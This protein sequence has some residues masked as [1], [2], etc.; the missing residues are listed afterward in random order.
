MKRL[1]MIAG[2]LVSFPSVVRA[3]YFDFD[4]SGLMGG[5]YGIAQTREN[6]NV[7]NDPYR[8]VYRADVTTKANYH[9]SDSHYIGVH[10]NS[11]LVLREPDTSYPHGDWRFYPY[12]VDESQAGKFTLGY[13][14]NAAYLLHKGARDITFFKIDDSNMTYFLSNPNWKNG[15]K[16]V[17]YQTPKSTSI[18]NDGRSAKISYFTPMLGN[19][20]LGFSYA[21][22]NANRRG[23]NSRYADYETPEDGYV[24][25][26]QNKWKIKDTE[27]YTSFGYGIFNRT[28][29]EASF[30][31]TLIHGDWNMGMGYKKAY[32]DGNKN[33]ITTV[34]TNP[35]T[36]AYFDNYRESQAWNISIGYK[37]GA[38]KTNLAYLHTKAEN[39]RNRDDLIVFSNLYSISE[40]FE[41]YLVGSYLNA[42]GLE[43]MSDNNNR[44]YAV[45]TGI[46]F[47]F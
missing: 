14:Y 30:G 45:V 28:D 42:K 37:Y 35:Q 7:K 36:P 32:V 34:S 10:A 8:W 13:T 4:I 6:N 47:R 46:G 3:G 18:M 25:A 1:L 26:M 39:T 17:S 43:R 15:R 16:S 23:M 38:Y 44:G 33:P 11:T 20:I 29:K 2:F 5:Y 12:L 9:L 27:I 19:T 31:I 24:A 41:L 22:E 21:P 40:H